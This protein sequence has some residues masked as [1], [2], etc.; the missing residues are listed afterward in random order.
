MPDLDFFIFFQSFD[1]YALNVAALNV[2]G[3][4]AETWLNDALARTS[5]VAAWI[6]S[7]YSKSPAL[8]LG[9][10]V[11][12]VIPAIATTGALFR[13]LWPH[14]PAKSDYVLDTSPV[15]TIPAS[16]WRQQAHLELADATVAPYAIRDGILRIGRETDNDLCLA[17]PTVHRYHAALERTPEAEFILSY[18]GD[19][20]EDGL[21]VNG[22]PVHRQ[23]LRGGE[24]LQIGAIKL[25][26]SLGPA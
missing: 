8:V 4:D 14:R 13:L 16:A 23:R 9:V 26:F 6:R 18:V 2:V 3:S 24:V 7:E 17:D 10:G 21:Y 15:H 20:D 25:R 5:D 22:R 11:A 19:P 1:V 12:L